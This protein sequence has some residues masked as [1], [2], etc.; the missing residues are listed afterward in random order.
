MSMPVCKVRGSPFKLRVHRWAERAKAGIVSVMLAQRI[1]AMGD[2]VI[3]W[4]GQLRDGTADERIPAGPDRAI[5]E[6]LYTDHRRLTAAVADKFPDL[7]GPGEQVQAMLDES[8]K[9]STLTRIDPS[10]AS[11]WTLEAFGGLKRLR[12]LLN[13]G[14][15]LARRMYMGHLKELCREFAGMDLSE[16]QAAD[17]ERK[18]RESVE[19][20]FYF[21]VVLVS[22]AEYQTTPTKL[23]QRARR[24]DL[25]SMERLMR[26]D[27]NA[28]RL[29]DI[30]NWERSLEG[31]TR[32]MWMKQMR[33]WSEEGLNH[34]QFK[35]SSVKVMLGGLI[36]ALM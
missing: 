28:I 33:R 29:P 15:R 17:F 32:T 20:H 16:E 5:L 13:S 21:R 11:Q 3:D 34:G 23:L 7:F 1:A 25:K 12:R 31:E 10:N 2:M 22:I 30:E 26:V 36:S 35:R 18:L 4:M 27:A 9:L 6:M 19:L 8:R 14:F 24:G